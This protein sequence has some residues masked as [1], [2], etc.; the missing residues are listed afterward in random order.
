MFTAQDFNVGQAT[1]RVRRGIDIDAGCGQLEV[2][3]LVV[4]CQSTVNRFPLL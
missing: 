4:N 3:A 2:A 1:V